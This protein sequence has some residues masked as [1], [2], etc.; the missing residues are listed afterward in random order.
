MTTK[1]PAK[2]AVATMPD[3]N[4]TYLQKCVYSGIDCA[5][6]GLKD[7]IC[8]KQIFA[9][10]DAEQLWGYLRVYWLFIWAGG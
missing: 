9:K 2:D 5:C 8:I 7:L 4:I 6:N 10:L 1:I 3:T